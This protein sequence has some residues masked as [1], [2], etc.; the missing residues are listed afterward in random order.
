[1]GLASVN[2]IHHFRRV[3]SVSIMSLER[4]LELWDLSSG[5]LDVIRSIPVQ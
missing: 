2:R 1:M 4:I 3:S 5:D